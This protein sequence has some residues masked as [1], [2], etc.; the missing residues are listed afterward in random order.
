[1]VFGKVCFSIIFEA[2][3]KLANTK[4]YNI[5]FRKKNI[6]CFERKSRVIRNILSCVI[7]L[8]DA[9]KFCKTESK[10][11]MIN[12]LSKQVAKKKRELIVDIL[13]YFVTYLLF[14]RLNFIQKLSSVK[15]MSKIPGFYVSG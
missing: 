5:K 9:A 10:K 12:G 11:L 7:I 15:L 13:I 4:N 2:I 1:M 8:Y 3:K 6:S 14:R